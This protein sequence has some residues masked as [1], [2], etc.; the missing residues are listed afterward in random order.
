MS[1]SAEGRYECTMCGKT[2]NDNSPKAVQKYDM[3]RHVETHM[4]GLKYTCP[5]CHKTY[6]TRGSLSNHRSLSKH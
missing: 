2:S 5:L 3:K 4:S 1:E 6:K